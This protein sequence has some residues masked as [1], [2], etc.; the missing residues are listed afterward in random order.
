MPRPLRSTFPFGVWHLT[1][2]G[3]DGCSIFGDDDDRLHFLALLVR[4]ATQLRWRFH[5]YCLMGNH[6]HL[7]VRCGQPELSTGMA[8]INALHARA[9][10]ARWERRGHL[11]G[12]RFAT[13]EVDDDEYLRDAC[14]YVVSNPV[15]AGI[16]IRWE[17]W[18]WSG[19]GRPQLS[20][21]VRRVRVPAL[22]IPVTSS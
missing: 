21:T 16:C 14:A 10:N 20:T 22:T 4:T 18:P 5:A 3:V 9:F 6:Y 11:F 12:A 2:R 13:R 7:L 17:E 19:L 1:S 8:R 15:R